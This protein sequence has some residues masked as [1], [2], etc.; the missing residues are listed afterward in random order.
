MNARLEAWRFLVALLNGRNDSGAAASLERVAA[1]RPS[2]WTDLISLANEHLVTTALWSGL[3]RCGLE[4]LLPPAAADYLRS[5][6][7]F[8]TER[9]RAILAQLYEVVAALNSFGI[10]PMPL[11]GSSYLVAGMFPELGDRYLS[12]IDLLVAE[13]DVERAEATL[14]QLGYRPASDIDY[15]RHHHLVPMVHNDRPVAIEVHRS[16]VPRHAAPAIPVAELWAQSE[17]STVGNV[18]SRLACPT[19]A[20]ML[21]FVHSQVIDRDGSLLL[22]PLRLF[23]DV[24]LLQHQHG[25]S[26]DWRQNFERASKVDAAAAFRRYLYVLREITGVESGCDSSLADAAYFLLCKST[27]AWPAFANLV[28]RADGWARR[29]GVPR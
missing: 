13:G 5:F 21:S 3:R 14:L 15:G 10:E 7:A 1:G 18:R 8:N 25:R 19:D 9:N 6:C 4:G 28:R 17:P 2:A 29:A 12:D 20:A 24:R 22:M 27:V 26:I 16:P 11:K 23:H